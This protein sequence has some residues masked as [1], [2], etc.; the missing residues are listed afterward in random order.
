[1]VARR[2]PLPS[3]YGAE[4]ADRDLQAVKSIATSA[5]SALVLA[6][7]DVDWLFDPFALQRVEV[8]GQV[9]IRPLNDNLALLLNL[10]EYA[11]GDET[12]LSIRSR[13]RLQRPFVRVAELFKAAEARYRDDQ[14]LLVSELR[15][16]EER[17][18]HLVAEAQVQ[19]ADDLPREF[20]EQVEGLEAQIRPI[21]KRLRDIRRSMREEVEGLGRRLTVANLLAGPVLVLLTGLAAWSFRRWRI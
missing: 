11:T 20:R 8:A 6:V 13:G 14:A 12:L 3:A 21:R 9:V 5:P 19:S 10:V 4:V 1:V 2:G 18:A 7:A 15:D 16:S 17:I